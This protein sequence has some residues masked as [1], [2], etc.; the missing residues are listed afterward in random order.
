MGDLMDRTKNT[1]TMESTVLAYART[2]DP[3]LVG[4]IIEYYDPFIRSLVS[5]AIRKYG[6]KDSGVA[7]REDYLSVG[8]FA[9]L[10]ALDK[11]KPE[12]GS[13][14]EFTRKRVFG[15]V[16]DEM[17]AIS[18]IPRDMRK[19]EKEWRKYVSEQGKK[20]QPSHYE[21]FHLRF[22]VSP[23]RLGQ[24]LACGH[25]LSLDQMLEEVASVP[26]GQASVTDACLEAEKLELAQKAISQL[27]ERKKIVIL[28]GLRGLRKADIAKQGL[29]GRVKRSMI[30]RL[31]SEAVRMMQESIAGEY[32]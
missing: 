3:D 10:K 25:F 2:R 8:K 26:S 20:Q 29:A 21:D 17:R 31:H 27:P 32:N 7:D 24:I 6:I 4:P 19:V 5:G 15:A 18:D 11:Y 9:F 12:L 1:Q 13:L 16:L 14:A 30:S 23:Y 28:A 22:R